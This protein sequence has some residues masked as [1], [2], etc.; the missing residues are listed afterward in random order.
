ML[1]LAQVLNK[2]A[3]RLSGLH[4][5]VLAAAT[6]LIERSYAV[7]VPIL[8]TQGLRTIAEQDALY[9]QGANPAG[10]DRDECAR[11]VQLSQ[12]W[13]GGGFCAAASEWLGRLLGYE[14]ER[15]SEWD[16][17]LAGGGAAR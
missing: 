13:I 12:L 6:A 3:A 17:G 14:Q 2:S 16:P 9:A 5:A 1:T 15:E 8:I 4:P 11:R 10:S 7:G